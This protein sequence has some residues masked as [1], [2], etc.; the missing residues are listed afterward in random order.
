MKIISAATAVAAV[1]A[2]TAAGRGCSSAQVPP[3][4]P[5]PP[6][7]CVYALPRNKRERP[8]PRH[9]MSQSTNVGVDRNIYGIIIC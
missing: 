7:D 6:H 1:V 2:D 9:I 8:L 4:T 5:P 3:P